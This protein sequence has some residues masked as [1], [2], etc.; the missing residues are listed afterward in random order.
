[1]S[2]NDGRFIDTERGTLS[3]EGSQQK[4]RQSAD[5]PL[6]PETEVYGLVPTSDANDPTYYNKPLLKQPVWIW[7]IP[8]YLYTGGAAGAAMMLG[9]AAQALDYEELEDLVVRC[10]WIGALGGAMSTAFLVHDLGRPSR[11]LNMLRVFRPTSPMSV[12]SWVLTVFGSSAGGA[13]LFS[14]SSGFLGTLGNIAAITGGLFGMP[15]ASYTSVL[16]SNTA[17]PVWQEARKTMP[18]LFIG[19]GISA[20]AALLDFVPLSEREERVTTVFAIAGGVIELA[21]IHA[22]EQET[23]V[24]PQVGRPLRHGVPGTLWQAAKVL[25]AAS[26]VLSL[27]PDKRRNTRRISG[28]CGTLSSLCVRFAIFYG[29]KQSAADPRASFHQQRAGYGAASAEN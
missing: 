17:V 2:E 11:F 1:V 15:L 23:N 29:G 20:A 3:G 6:T 25:S 10:R 18:F 7:S 27:I 9:A 21:G 8:A 22:V 24:V 12:G 28:I 16:L 13:A 19:S 5:F 14:R 26:L 4:I